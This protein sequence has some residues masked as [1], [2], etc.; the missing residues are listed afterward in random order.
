MHSYIEGNPCADFGGYRQFIIGTLPQLKKLD[1]TAVTPS[2]RILAKQELP[3]GP[4]I[5]PNTALQ[6]ETRTPC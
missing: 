6:A 2:E 4:C 3:A 1:G 5:S